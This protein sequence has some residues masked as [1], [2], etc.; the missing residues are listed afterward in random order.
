MRIGSV[1]V[2]PARSVAVTVKVYVQALVG[3]FCACRKGTNQDV[4][5]RPG[6][7]AT[8]GPQA[9]QAV[10]LQHSRWHPTCS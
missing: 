2:F 1:V 9:P 10:P 5:V 4:S 8:G 6:D 7:V 3:C